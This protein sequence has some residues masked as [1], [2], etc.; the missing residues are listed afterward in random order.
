MTVNIYKSAVF[1]PVSSYFINLRI[2]IMRLSGMT[3]PEELLNQSIS[4]E[5]NRQ[6]G[7]L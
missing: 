5:H 3:D 2:K 1:Q 7:V 4:A 6:Q